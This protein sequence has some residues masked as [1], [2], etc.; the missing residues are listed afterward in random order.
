MNHVCIAI[1]VLHITIEAPFGLCP[2]LE[3]DGTK[4]SGSIN[5]MM[6]LGEKFGEICLYAQDGGSVFCHPHRAAY[7]ARCIWRGSI[8]SYITVRYL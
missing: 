5:I 6:Y 1:S 8:A 4:I 7:I 2:Y 3:V